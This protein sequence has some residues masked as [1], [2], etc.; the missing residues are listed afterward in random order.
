[1]AKERDEFAGTEDSGTGSAI[2]PA[3]LA[4]GSGSGDSGGNDSGTDYARDA[5][6]NIIR[7]ADGSPRKKRG[8]KAGSGG[9]KS[10]SKNST[11]NLTEATEGLSR[12]LLMLHMGLANVSNAPEFA[13]DKSESD[14]LA[15]A[16]V[17]VLEQFDIKPNPK[18]EAI[19]GLITACGI[20]YGPRVVTYRRRVS[21][22][23]SE[24]TG[25]NEPLIFPSR[26]TL[27]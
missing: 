2:D 11:R 18:A 27:A 12:V 25:D 6:G 24:A 15:S 23:Q 22:K 17:N 19:F 4:P 10:G 26:N 16:S 20:V 21:A 1:M 5:S 8:R 13:L 9:G 7:N 3:S 14:M